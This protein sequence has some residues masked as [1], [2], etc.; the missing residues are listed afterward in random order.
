MINTNWQ[1]KYFSTIKHNIIIMH[2]RIRVTFC[3]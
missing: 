2:V 3:E 1:N